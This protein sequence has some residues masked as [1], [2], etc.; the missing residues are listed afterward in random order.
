MKE[1]AIKILV[2]V[3]VEERIEL[4]L[5]Q[6]TVLAVTGAIEAVGEIDETL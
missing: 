2:P 6:V 5:R 3:P 4:A 1:K